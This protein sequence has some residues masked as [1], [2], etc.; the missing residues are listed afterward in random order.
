MEK[1]EFEGAPGSTTDT[2][3]VHSKPQLLHEA[4]GQQRHGRRRSINERRE[5]QI[6]NLRKRAFRYTLVSSSTM[7]VVILIIT[8]LQGFRLWGFDLPKE[9]LYALLV[10]TIGKVA[11]SLFIVMRF[12]F[13]PEATGRE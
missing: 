10:A 8:L 11:E 2:A 5:Q 12:L 6:L 7:L 4:A 9:I 1:R 13:G 3:P